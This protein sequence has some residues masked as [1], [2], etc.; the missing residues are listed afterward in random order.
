LKEEEE[1]NEEGDQKDNKNSL[2][3]EYLY[4][5]DDLIREIF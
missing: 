2:K 4:D 5:R 1:N 3:S